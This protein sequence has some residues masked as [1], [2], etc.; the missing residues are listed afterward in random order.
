MLAEIPE[1]TLCLA[2]ILYHRELIDYLRSNE[3]AIWAWFA[4]SKQQ[5][6]YRDS[7]RLEL[8]K[9]TYRLSQE[10]HGGLYRAGEQAANKLGLNVALT[11]YQSQQEHGGVNAFVCCLPDEAHIVLV[12]PVLENL[13]ELEILA[14]IGHELGHYKLRLEESGRVEIADR[15]LDAAATDVR[16]EPSHVFSAM[17][18]RQYSEIYADRCSLA[19]CGNLN[20]V[21]GCLVKVSTGLKVV[22]PTSYIAQAHEIF[23]KNEVSTEGVTHPESFI[24]VRA[25]SK[26]A[27]VDADVERELQRM[28][29]GPVHIEKLDLTRQ[30]ELKNITRE[31]IDVVLDRKWMR[32][33]TVLAHARILF[34][35]YAPPAGKP[36]DNSLR[37]LLNHCDDSIKHYCCSIMLDFAA[38]DSSLDEVSL[39]HVLSIAEQL[40]MR[41]RLEELANKELRITKKALTRIRKEGDE[42][43]AKAENS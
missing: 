9:S 30:R 33:E 22:D 36:T 5:S 8:L 10:S 38:V 6:A 42:M 27:A 19:V 41:D 24:R 1:P 21:V 34:H 43:L 26:W 31:L 32:T 12:G 37:S 17:R 15:V 16:A 3:K 29:E 35:D 2:P 13:N 20:A 23:S 25:L 39:A 40:G 11:F 4:E 7:V 14:L 18:F 28:I